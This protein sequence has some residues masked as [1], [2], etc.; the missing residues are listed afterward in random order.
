MVA[1]VYVVMKFVNI[2]MRKRSVIDEAVF[3]SGEL[4]GSVMMM[5]CQRWLFR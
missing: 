3:L 5:E 1:N 4:L 2:C